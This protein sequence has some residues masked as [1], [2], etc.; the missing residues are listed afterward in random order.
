MA[1][2]EIRIRWSEPQAKHGL[3]RALALLLGQPQ[4]H[5]KAPVDLERFLLVNDWLKRS[6]RPGDQA[7]D[8]TQILPVTTTRPRRT[9]QTLRRKRF[10]GC[11]AIC[12]ADSRLVS[13]ETLAVAG[14]SS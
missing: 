7:P 5:L 14:R 8:R 4:P 1:K 2:H 11:A 10:S 13:R 6:S 12:A 9:G 3:M